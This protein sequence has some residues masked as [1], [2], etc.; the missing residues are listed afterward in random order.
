VAISGTLA[1]KSKEG[2]GVHAQVVSSRGGRRGEWTAL[3]NE[4]ATAVARVEVAAGDTV[5]FVVDMRS[6]VNSDSFQWA[7]AVHLIEA[8]DGA[9]SG[10]WKASD[11]FAGPAPKGPPRLKTWEK[12][13]QALLMTNEF[14]F[15]D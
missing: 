6:N 4:T 11:D 9:G 10:D 13:A 5:D 12:Y 14:V 7:P 15:V 2:D 1:H 8:S 3:T